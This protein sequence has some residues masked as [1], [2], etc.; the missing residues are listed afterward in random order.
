M[1]WFIHS[2]KCPKRFIFVMEIIYRI[3]WSIKLSSVEEMW[4]AGAGWAHAKV[5][6]RWRRAQRHQ[7]EDVGTVTLTPGHRPPTHCSKAPSLRQPA[8]KPNQW[9]AA[10]QPRPGPD[11]QTMPSQINAAG[12]PGQVSSGG[13]G[14]VSASAQW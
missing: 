5:A 10:V 7:V 4:A 1:V 14:P 9:Y 11:H 3:Y 6:A 2:P 13:S 8:T 12:R